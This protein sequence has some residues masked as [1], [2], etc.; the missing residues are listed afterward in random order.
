MDKSRSRQYKTLKSSL[1]FTREFILC[2]FSLL[3][4]VY[5]VTVITV[6]G[7]TLFDI[8][9]YSIELIRSILNVESTDLFAIFKIIL[10]FII[11]I[12]IFMVGA[13]ISDYRSKVNEY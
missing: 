13:I 3:L 10:A 5:C 8:P 11:F 1:N 9:T 7:G 6:M 2:L 4:W 12:L